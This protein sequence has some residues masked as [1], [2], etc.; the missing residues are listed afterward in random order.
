MRYASSRLPSNKP[1][2][3]YGTGSLEQL[4]ALWRGIDVFVHISDTAPRHGVDTDEDLER[5]RKI[6]T[7]SRTD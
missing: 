1:A 6:L 4:R 2:R 7:R 5:V 3:Y